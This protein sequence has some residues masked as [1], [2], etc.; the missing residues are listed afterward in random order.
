MEKLLVIWVED[1]GRFAIGY[2]C[3]GKQNVSKCP[4]NMIQCLNYHSIEDIDQLC[5]PLEK[6]QLVD[7][8]QKEL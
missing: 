4:F 5:R 8:M 2:G 7:L 3:D 6:Q 1:I